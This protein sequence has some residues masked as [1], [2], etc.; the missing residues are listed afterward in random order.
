LNGRPH[1]KNFDE[2]WNEL[3]PL[4]EAHARVDDRRHG[5]MC[6]FKFIVISFE[7]VVQDADKRE[8][9]LYYAFVRR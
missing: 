8:L 9:V 4:L 1:N 7:C 5:K 2:F 6:T 3:N